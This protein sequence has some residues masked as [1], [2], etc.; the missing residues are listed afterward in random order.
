MHSF[1]YKINQAELPLNKNYNIN[2]KTIIIKSQ[3]LFNSIK[4]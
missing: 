2:L 3:N 4:F 1:I